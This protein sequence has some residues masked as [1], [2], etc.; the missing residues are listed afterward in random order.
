[1][2]PSGELQGWAAAGGRRALPRA[3]GAGH[4]GAK[5]PLSTVV[6]GKMEANLR[7]V[8]LT[9]QRGEVPGTIFRILLVVT[10]QPRGNASQVPRAQA[11]LSESWRVLRDDSSLLGDGQPQPLAGRQAS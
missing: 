11:D 6:M 2:R 10:S 4:K 9:W 1:M 7:D 8:G 5:A 3:G